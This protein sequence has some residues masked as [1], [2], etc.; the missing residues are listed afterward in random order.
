[1]P[2]YE[3]AGHGPLWWVAYLAIAITVVTTM[4]LVM[5]A[6]IARAGKAT[7]PRPTTPAADEQPD[8]VAGRVS[9]PVTAGHDEP[10]TLHG[11]A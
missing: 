6:G 2:M 3:G 7:A 5:L 4:M 10:P 8:E 11:A 1:M 9:A